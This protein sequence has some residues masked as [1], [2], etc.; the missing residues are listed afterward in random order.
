VF[1]RGKRTP[2]VK[3]LA[4]KIADAS[5]INVPTASCTRKAPIP[6]EILT[7]LETPSS[8][9]KINPVESTLI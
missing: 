2:W 8:S 7:S 5:G 4:W 1:K 3:E 9:P 6:S